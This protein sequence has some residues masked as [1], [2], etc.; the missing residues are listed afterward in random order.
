MTEGINRDHYTEDRARK[1]KA[2]IAEF[3]KGF[4]LDHTS[5]LTDFVTLSE[6]DRNKTA[7]LLRAID[8]VHDEL[9][10]WAREGQDEHALEAKVAD[11]RLHRQ[12]RGLLLQSS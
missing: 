8:T 12:P 5:D 6:S 11:R 2:T 10:A 7:T 4:K 1:A 3:L 9:E